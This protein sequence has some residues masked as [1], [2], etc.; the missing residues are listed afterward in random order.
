MAA[1]VLAAALAACGG[2]TPETTP[3]TTPAGT[4]TVDV[5]LATSTL[6]TATAAPTTTTTLPPTA[7]PQRLDRGADATAERLHSDVETVAGISVRVAGSPEEAQLA[8]WL[9]TQVDVVT[10]S[11]AATEDVPLPNGKTSIN[12]WAEPV[13]DG[14]TTV[15]LGA[16]IDTVPGSPGLDDNG[17]G[18]VVL[19]ELL[20]RLIDDPVEGLT[21]QVAWFGA[22]E[23][24]EGMT[25]SDHHYGSRQ[26]AARLASEGASPDWMLS[27]DMVGVGERLFGVAYEGTDP[28]AARALAEAGAA[29]GV[30]VEILDRGDISDHEGFAQ[31][32]SRAAMLWRP[33]NPA[34]H[35]PDDNH[36]DTALLLENIA[37]LEAFLQAGGTG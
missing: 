36:V 25:A 14:A 27:V 15:L 37:V 19:L 2:T 7:P 5:P 11:P 35:T 29:V 6:P 18:T 33:D 22:E 20:R 30:T 3:T 1:S 16:H 26:A 17:S 31:A 4:T 10:G 34:W 12:V 28:A 32:G 13:G 21:V 8:E 23:V 9:A 24:L